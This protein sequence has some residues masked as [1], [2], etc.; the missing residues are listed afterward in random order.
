MFRLIALCVLFLVGSAGAAAAQAQAQAQ[1]PGQDR[2]ALEAY[3]THV[4]ESF[5]DD[6]ARFK[7]LFGTPSPA[8]LLVDANLPRLSGSPRILSMEP[9][10][11]TV[12]LTGYVRLENSGDQTTYAQRFSGIYR[13]RPS[14]D[15]WRVERRI[16]FEVNRIR[17]HDLSLDLDPAVGVRAIDEM[18]VEVGG[19]QG[20]F[21]GM[22]TNAT[23]SAVTVDGRRADHAL[24][25]GL[26]WVEARPGRR[27][28]KIEYALPVEREPG[29][30][31]AMF[32][33][34]FGHMRNQY[35]W[36]P[37]FGFGVDNG[38]ADFRLTIRAP[39]RLKIAT[40]L[41]Q[42]ET[43][44]DG[45]RTVTARSEA[46]TGA[47]TW[48]YDEAWEPRTHAVGAMELQLFATPDYSP[49]ADSFTQ[50]GEETW[51]V[52]SARFGAPGLRRIAVIQARGRDGDGW[53]FFSNQGIFTGAQG[54]VLSRDNAFPVRAFFDHEVAHLWT[55]PSGATRN[56][57]SE[58]WATYA[59]SLVISKRHGPEA[60]R[61]FWSD[62]ARLFLTNEEM[63]AGVLS[64]DPN[65]SGV[66]YSK[67]AWTLAM[68]E[69]VLG[70]DSFD[71]GVRAF[72][73]APQGQTDYA[74]FVRGFGPDAAKAE[75]F[76]KPWVE[77]QGAPRMSLV[78][79]GDRLVLVRSGGDYWLPDFSVA[80][81]TADGSTRWLR[82]D[83]AGDRT[84]VP[85]GSDVVRVRLDPAEAYLLAGDRVI[86]AADIGAALR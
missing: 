25:D 52:L 44:A 23:L 50:A 36:H 56:F 3:L 82:V 31:S 71:R 69:R 77:G 86:E 41:P 32:G 60:A 28:L 30:N 10:G 66:A 17:S 54:G 14:A 37:F 29:G 34:Q 16:P 45:V 75:R 65:N 68:L 24:Q 85:A 2:A 21:A 9:D 26:L 33:D 61:W 43:V 8:D 57:L 72:V 38:L 58:G 76:L 53:H 15:G 46:P 81:E 18:V 80:V 79:E 27:R 78:R 42:T 70:R 64:D 83:V 63:R 1:G 11:A 49:A 51:A 6:P 20:F 67:G 7:T 48:A 5:R 22:N 47:V 12:L 19:A 39:E 40:D 4:S 59:E 13:V 84:P 55:R 74:A 35:W 73:A 62:Q